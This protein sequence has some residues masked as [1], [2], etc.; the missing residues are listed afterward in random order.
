MV[1][2][3]Q[4]GRVRTRKEGGTLASLCKLN[5]GT[6]ERFSVPTSLCP[7]PLP[8]GSRNVTLA[9][10]NG[11]M[12]TPAA[13]SKQN[14]AHHR[15]EHQGPDQQKQRPQA[16]TTK[17]DRQQRKCCRNPS[18]PPPHFFLLL[19]RCPTCSFE[20][21]RCCGRGPCRS[22]IV[23]GHWVSGHIASWAGTGR[24]PI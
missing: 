6:E 21:S 9:E 4:A 23:L 2:K 17:H 5:C 3:L 11:K 22:L 8:Y 20:P 15:R 7:T 19:G 16:S 1:Y 24:R 14:Q 10:Q 18:P 12:R 13:E